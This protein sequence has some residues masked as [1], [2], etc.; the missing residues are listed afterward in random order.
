MAERIISAPCARRI[1]VSGPFQADFTVDPA[2]H[3]DLCLRFRAD[4][5]VL[6]RVRARLRDG[7]LE[8]GLEDGT[9]ADHT[10]LKVSARVG[11]LSELVI[12]GRA[13]AN[14]HHLS[15]GAIALTAGHAS[16]IQAE[17]AARRWQLSAAGQ[18]AIRVRAASAQAL[19]VS[20]GDASTVQLEGA[21][22]ELDLRLSGAARVLA[23]RPGF[24]AQRAHMQLSGAARASVCA[25]ELVAGQVRFP[26][27]LTL[28][29]RGTIDLQGAYRLEPLS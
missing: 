7:A 11:G 10:Q 23:A 24:V 28:A 6:P 13:Y 16:V 12:A 14:V 22:A 3:D 25:V 1:V 5:N 2:Q 21:C 20:A 18:S 26:A 15:G 17:G 27:R 19:T 9:Y 29:C 8:I 4:D